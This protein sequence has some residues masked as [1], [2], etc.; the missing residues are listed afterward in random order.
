MAWKRNDGKPVY[1]YPQALDW[2]FPPISTRYYHCSPDGD[3]I[4]GGI[5]SL[6]GVHPTAIGHG[7]VAHEFLK[8]MKKAGVR[9]P[10]GN[11]VSPDLLDWDAIIKSDTLYQKP[12]RLMQEIYQH[13][14]SLNLIKDLCKTL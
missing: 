1:D 13:N 6:D 2:L 12:I 14:R 4:K 8:T 5:F 10:E 7:I 3:F 9:D 11:E